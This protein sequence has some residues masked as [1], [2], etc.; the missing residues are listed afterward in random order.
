MRTPAY[1]LYHLSA[2]VEW[3][4]PPTNDPYAPF[5]AIGVFKDR[6]L[7]GV[8]ISMR[9]T[10][11]IYRSPG[12]DEA[13]RALAQVVVS[14]ALAGQLS[15]LSGH[16]EQIAALIPLIGAARVDT[17]DR[18]HFRTLRPS[19]MVATERVPPPG[20]APPR[21][22][23]GGDMER[24]IDF[25]MRGFYSLARLPSRAAWH[26]RLTE[27][28]SYRTLFLIEDEKSKIASAALSSAE[29]AGGAMLGG[30]AT[31]PEYEGHGLSTLCV[32]ALCTHLFKLNMPL[33]SL[34]YLPNNTPAA[35]VYEKLG[36]QRD[37]EWLLATLGLPML[38]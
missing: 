31:L 30:V 14:Q 33:I 32:G 19:D 38:S 7:V 27:Q 29:S 4:L 3:E 18:C 10:G 22:A 6:E 26:A 8:A 20:F 35:R 11:G 5:W 28:I 17:P 9:G 21:I 16:Q 24:L 2:L 1:N 15:L 36:F 13:L 37:G 23:A 34:F 25:Y 12:D